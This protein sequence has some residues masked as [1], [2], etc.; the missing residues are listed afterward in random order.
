MPP[1]TGP[2]APE[3]ARAFEQG[4]FAVPARAPGLETSAVRTDWVV[5]IIRVAFTDSAIVYPKVVMEQ[6]LFDTTGAVP[7]GSMT[8]YYTW[9]SGHRL[10][11]RGE[12]VATVLLP[13]DRNYYAGDAWGVNVQGTPNND[14]GLFRDAISACD[15]QVDFSRFDLDGDGY[16]DMLWVVHAGPGGEATTS[17][18]DLWSLTSR[19]TAGWNNGAVVETNDLL[20]G[21]T[22]ENPRYERIDR[23][24]ILPELSGLHAGQLSEIGVYCHEFGHTLGL[25][26]LYDTSVL[27]GTTNVG[28]GNWSLMSTGAYGGDSQTPESPSGFGAWCMLWLGWANRI[29][30]T[31]DTTLVLPP[32]IDGGPLL[33]FWF[34][35][36]DSP[37]HF[38]IENRIRESFDHKLPN[39]G[40]IVNQVDEA[41]V[42]ARIS[43]NRINT[44][45]TPGLR[46]LEA[47]GNFDMFYGYDRGDA[48]DPFP[49]GVKR[50]R[51]DDV[52]TPSTRTFLGAPT[53]IA[54]E[55]ITRTG[56][57]VSVRVRVRS[58]GWNSPHDLAPGASEPVQSFGAATRAVVSPNG[59]AWQVS[60][61]LVG[62]R[63]AVLLRG[64]PWLQPWQPAEVVEQGSGS[65]T[66]PTLARVG[67]SDLAVAWI[68]SS[69]GDPGQVWYRAR[70]HGHWTVPHVM[71]SSIEGCLTP[72][73]AADGRGR[74][75]LSWL[76]L[77]SGRPRLRFLEFLYGT[78]YGQPVTV[79]SPID[80]PTA[81]SITAAGNGHAYLVWPDR[82]GGPNVVYAC[83]FHPDSGL[84]ARFRLT[85]QSAPSQPSVSAV[86]DSNGVLYSVWQV[87]PGA[88]SEIHFQRRQPAG[89]PSTRDTTLDA[90]GDALQ[91]PRIALDPAGGIHVAYERSVT[92]GQRVRYKLCRP[93][94]GWDTRATEVSDD[95]DM[96]TSYIE[97][98]PTSLGN[99]TVLWTGYDGATQHLRARER[100]LDGTLVTAVPAPPDRRAPSFTVG[101]NPLRAGQTLEFS[102]ARLHAGDVVELLDPTGRRVAVATAD[103]RGIA[104]LARGE[105]SALRPGLYF[106]SVRGGDSRGRVVVLR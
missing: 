90:L 86:V 19:A 89:R 87:S 20:P 23:F 101:P 102:G 30:P 54:L 29:R 45:P 94:L 22:Q 68:E 58:P 46:I 38:L 27:G 26:D 6:R 97:L 7:T 99:V 76:E 11:V 48:N 92:A 51:I 81:P 14:Y 55:N 24:T 13:H 69:A 105:T 10:N 21:S 64:R 47:D 33:E 65:A 4:L 28:P 103:A 63:L 85:P 66:D 2:L 32:I 41:M 57:N 80:L 67:A 62:G 8:Q 104:R 61:E 31:Q 84:S 71:T 25:P 52:T 1:H 59:D 93:Q 70:V 100:S 49:G 12:I 106:A 16:V 91:N 83:R 73:I 75:F 95:A 56:R 37:E 18:R 9:A 17:R 42:G 44:G 72:S 43:G 5:P 74:V 53:N 3:L 78:P 98:L 77:I 35:G 36:E 79:T 50:T 15:G 60:S 34:Q 88:G 96:T 39:D 82:G 40:L